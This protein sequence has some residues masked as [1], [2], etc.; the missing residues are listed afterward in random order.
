MTDLAAWVG[1]LH[2][3]V[4]RMLS[5]WD[6]IVKTKI[7]GGGTLAPASS[8]APLTGHDDCS[9]AWR[10]AR[11]GACSPPPAPTRRRECGINLGPPDI[12]LSRIERF[13]T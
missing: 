2:E 6:G 3:T 4:E 10:S 11:T 9:V 12:R 1:L 7:P 5:K 13:S 8:C